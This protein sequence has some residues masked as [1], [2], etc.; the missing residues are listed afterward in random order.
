MQKP[1]STEGAAAAGSAITV[2]TAPA[3][4]APDAERIARELYGLEGIAEPL[5]SERDQNFLIRAAAGRQFVVKIANAQEPPEILDFQ[6]QVM[7]RLQGQLGDCAVPCVLPDRCGAQIASVATPAGARHFVRLCTWLPG[8]CLGSVK[9]HKPELLADWG[10]VVA[11]LD[12]ALSNF[13]HPA[14][15]RAFHWDLQ[16]A[17]EARRWL[18][19]IRDE[20]ARDRVARHLARFER[21]AL[22]ELAKLPAQVIHNDANDYN[23]LVTPPDSSERRIAGL[24]D[25]GD[26]VY[27]PA[28]CDLAVAATYALLGKPDPIAAAADGVRGYHAVRPLSEREIAVLHHLICARLCLSVVLAAVQSADAPGNEYL[29][30]SERQAWAALERLD[31]ISPRWAEAVYRDACGQPACLRAARIVEWLRA[32][33]DTFAPVVE[34]DPRTSRLRFFDLSAASLELPS[35]LDPADAPAFTAFIFD[36][37]RAASAAVGVG[38]Y[39]E[40]RICYRARQFE[41]P[42]NDGPQWRTVH[43]GVDLFLPPGSPV[44]APLEGT[45]HS[46][47]DNAQPLDYGPTILLEHDAGGIPF[48]TL[49]GHLSRE[50]LQGLRPGARVRRGAKIGSIGEARVNGGWAPHLHFQIICDVLDRRGDFPG[51]AAPSQRR[52]WLSLCPDPNL[53]LSLPQTDAPPASKS[54]EEILAVRRAHLGPSLTLS[55]QRPL[56]VVRGFRHHLYDADGRIYLDAV[57]NVPHVGHCHP[58]VVAAGQ[59]QMAV[60]NTNTRYLYSPMAEYIERLLEHLPEPLRVCFFVCSGSEANE[61]ALRLARAH[62]KRRGVLVLE[63]GYHGNTASLVE[64]SHYKFAGPGGEGA[65]PHVRV[66]PLPDT[67]RGP[68]SGGD[69]GARYARLAA[70]Q[71]L[72]AEAAGFPVGAFLAESLPSSAGMIVP[73]EGFLRETYGHVRAAGGVCIA[74]EVQAGFGRTGRH[75]WGFEAHGVVPDIVTL[76]KP[77]G[78]GHPMAAVITTREIADS[79]CTGMEYF[80]TFGGNPV[81]CAI[82]LAVLDVLR[83]ERLQEN[84]RAVGDQLLAGLRRLQQ[85]HE[86]IGDVRGM[87]LFIGVELVRSRRTLE[88]AAEA[89][90]YIAERMRDRGVLAGTEGPRRNLLKIRPPMCFSA[91]DAERLLAA[92]AEV[93]DEDFPR[94]AART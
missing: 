52:I 16:R 69:A 51:V 39:A 26:M 17:P 22:S 68:H 41:T 89:A 58:R 55:Y 4:T 86:I 10:A 19:A 34:P 3:F 9:P 75:F 77:I 59:R 1:T 92:L 81:S 47:E 48:F 63:G 29:R 31:G 38:R 82:G 74:D 94:A 37:M 85:Q 28:V 53:I 67:Y 88:P 64:V 20:A 42:G 15:R 65:P 46:F 71:I 32:N 50:S 40:P 35:G 57:N 60:L 93:L 23:V 27:A 70:E 62:T 11:R 6:Y 73:P 36:A 33:R 87:G 21:E 5:P 56:H 80:N 7:R 14:M 8:I 49:Y 43:L 44:F 12:V 30:I 13:S 61:L 78:N 79:F 24:L 54:P 25:F 66:A 18:G 76:G 83:D 91:G 72:R 90:A 45:V 84:A 2:K